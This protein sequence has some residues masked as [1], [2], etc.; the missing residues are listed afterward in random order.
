MR[1]PMQCNSSSSSPS[2]SRSMSIK[3]LAN[4][5]DDNSHE[6]SVHEKKRFR[7]EQRE[8]RSWRL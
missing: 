7:A 2:F 4:W 3:S 5:A 1:T 8:P 6:D